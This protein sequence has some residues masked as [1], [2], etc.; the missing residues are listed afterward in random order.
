MTTK[1][2]EHLLRE[3]AD[4]EHRLPELDLVL[5]SHIKTLNVFGAYASGDRIGYITLEDA[6]SVHP[7]AIRHSLIEEKERRKG[8]GRALYL[9][10]AAL[11]YEQGHL[12]RSD[13]YK[14]VSQLAAREWIEFQRRGLAQ[15][16]EKFT[17]RAGMDESSK[18]YAQFRPL[19]QLE[20]LLPQSST[21]SDDDLWKDV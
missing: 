1:A 6:D 8:N 12:L 4:P 19:D 20:T 21:R 16:P 5:E 2:T 13:P 9:G 18:G 3:I 11:A 17:W 14:G 7:F 15:I 10:A